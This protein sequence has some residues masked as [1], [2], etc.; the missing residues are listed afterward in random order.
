LHALTHHRTTTGHPTTT[1]AWGPWTTG[2][3]HHLGTADRRRLTG[4]GLVPIDEASGLALFDAALASGEPV[5]LPLPVNRAALRRRAANGPLPAVLR[6]LAPPPVRVAASPATTQQALV[7]TLRGLPAHEQDEQLAQLVRGRIAAVL[8]HGSAD[9]VQMDQ[10][11][12]DLGFDSLM[13]VELRGVL[14]AAT[15]L[16]LPATLVFDHPTPE[17]VHELLRLE[18]LPGESSA[19]DDVFAEID[20]LE[21]GLAQLGDQHAARVRNRLR[22]LLAAWEDPGADTGSDD[23]LAEAD[24]EAVLGIIDDEL[25]RSDESGVK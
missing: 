4:T 23:E 17:A 9:A 7:D 20:R 8:G 16:R 10:Q 5:V 19:P 2:M 3:A 15:G 13:S 22:S 14:E 21:A 18:L 25:G 11:F 12:T 6:D 24:L 1:I